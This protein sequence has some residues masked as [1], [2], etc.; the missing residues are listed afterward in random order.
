MSGCAEETFSG[1]YQQLDAEPWLGKRI[2]FQASLR[3]NGTE[4]GK[5]AHLW[6]RIGDNPFPSD[7]DF[8]ENMANDPIAGE[9]WRTFKIE[10]QVPETSTS[11]SFG[12]VLTGTG[13]AW[14]DAVSI[15]EK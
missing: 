13:Q 7:A 6:L 14:L 10:A 3:T 15:E 9:A 5:G 4:P 11:I 12:A 1:L 2:R 8:Y